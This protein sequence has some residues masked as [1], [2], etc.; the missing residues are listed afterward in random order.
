MFHPASLLLSWFGFALSLQWLTLEWLLPIAFGSSLAAVVIAPERSLNLLRR[1]RWLLI[2]LAVLYFFMTPG[3][4]VPGVVGAIGITYEGL[5]QGGMQI[6]LLLA[7]LASLALL[8]RMIGTTGLLAGSH[9]LLSP[10]PWR[11]ATVVRLMLVLEYLE[12]ERPAHWREWLTPNPKKETTLPDKF[13]LAMPQFH[14]PDCALLLFVTGVVLIVMI[15][16]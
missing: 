13:V 11:E 1:S 15:R 6:A 10:F 7:V 2:S 9:W 4:F 16:S 8:H 12:Q 14:L 5:Q 3:E